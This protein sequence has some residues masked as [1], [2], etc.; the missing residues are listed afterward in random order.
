MRAAGR[1]G[2]RGGL[3][4]RFTGLMLALA[5]VL[6]AAL[7]SAPPAA[8]AELPQGNAVKDPEAILRNALPIKAPSSRTCSTAWRPPATTCGP[9]AGN[10]SPRW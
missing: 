1:T 4:R 2:D 5:L 9:S 3:L 6:G 7:L 10:P 8:L